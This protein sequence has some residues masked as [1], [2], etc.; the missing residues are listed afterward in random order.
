M[1]RIFSGTVVAAALAVGACGGTA[2]NDSDPIAPSIVG[3]TARVQLAIG[4]STEIDGVR[5]TFA[6]VSEDSRCPSD[7]DCVWQGNARV[8]LT[9]AGAGSTPTIG[10]NTTLEPVEVR[11]G[12]FNVSI[13]SLTPYP[14][15][16][17]PIDRDAYR[18]KLRLVERD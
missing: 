8:V 1:N 17:A 7:V 3:D 2:S 9:V 5:I 11:I 12:G 14:V 10:L 16:T 6:E 4:Q 15:S 13:E 18:V